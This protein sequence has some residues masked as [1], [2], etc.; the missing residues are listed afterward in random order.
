MAVVWASD[1]GDVCTNSL[2]SPIYGIPYHGNKVT[3]KGNVLES[4]GRVRKFTVFAV[5]PRWGEVLR[6]AVLQCY[7]ECLPYTPGGFCV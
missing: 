2:W 7:E 3:R 5:L 6:A 4:I 1:L